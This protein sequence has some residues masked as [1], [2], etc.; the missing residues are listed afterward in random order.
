M[1]KLSTRVLGM[2]ILSV[3]AAGIGGYR[4]SLDRRWALCGCFHH[5]DR[6][7]HCARSQPSTRRIETRLRARRQRLAVA[8]RQ[9]RLLS[10]CTMPPA[11]AHRPETQQ[12][13]IIFR[14]LPVPRSCTPAM[15]RVVAR[16]AGGVKRDQFGFRFGRGHRSPGP[17]PAMAG[18]RADILKELAVAFLR[19]TT[20][21]SPLRRNRFRSRPSAEP[22]RLTLM[23]LGP[24][25]KSILAPAI[26]Y[27][28]SIVFQHFAS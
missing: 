11:R 23:A 20:N 14:P 22:R 12:Q 24:S 25:S 5:T 8:R 17:A 27:Q 4:D 10:L 15:A 21:C 3:R 7:A 26:Q 18:A 13:V 16:Y 9:A 6:R 28:V 19:T 1:V 2:G